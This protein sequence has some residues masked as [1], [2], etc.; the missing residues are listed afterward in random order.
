M[1]ENYVLPLGDFYTNANIAAQKTYTPA[2]IDFNSFNSDH[3]FEVIK[4][5]D[6]L[7]ENT[8]IHLIKNYIDTIVDKTLS[9]ENYM[10]QILS[11]PKFVDAYYKSMRMIPLTYDRK[12]FANKLTYEYS[13]I[14]NPDKD[15]LS[16]FKEISFYVNKDTAT[17]L[18]G[19]GLHRN[20]ANELVVARY[21]SR[22]ENIN[23]Q[24]LNFCM[25]KYNEEIFSDQMT[26]WVYEQLFDSISTLFISSM[27]EVYSEDE[28]NRFGDDF[29]DVYGN[30]SLAI[31][32][33]LNNMPS[34]S[35][36][37]VIL[38]YIDAYID[39]FKTRPTLPRFTLRAL[40]SD[41]ER[42]VNV[43]DRLIAEGYDVP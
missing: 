27:L 35:I 36:R 17:K 19:I 24:R 11:H 28:L 8:I 39:W 14:D 2:H 4:N 9:E 37:Q 38:N 5:I 1:S 10:G 21:S 7:D 29:R 15:I 33:I 31:L 18:I 30:I 40:S 26:V 6:N 34:V 22:K 32:I 41:Y 12:L 13:I 42:I 43:V 16:K 3:F 25:C 23:V 20:I